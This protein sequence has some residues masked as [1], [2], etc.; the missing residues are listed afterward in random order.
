MTTTNANLCGKCHPNRVSA[1]NDGSGTWAGYGATNPGTHPVGSNVFTDTNGA[2]NSPINATALGIRTFG[3]VAD[4]RLG[5]KIITGALTLATGAGMTCVTCHAVHGVET[6]DGGAAL[7]GT[8][9]E[10]LL[11]VA[12]TGTMDG[13]A[14][15]GR[16]A[17]ARNFLCEACHVAAATWDPA[18]SLAY[19]GTNVPNPGGTQFTHP[20]DDLGARASAGVGDWA[21][22]P[23][24][25]GTATGWPARTSGTI[26]GNVGTTAPIC[27]SCHMPHPLASATAQTSAP[28]ITASATHILRSSETTLCDRCH[29][30]AVGN[31]HPTG[32]AMGRFA[33]SDIVPTGTTLQCG[34]C[35]V[36]S[37]AHNWAAAAGVGL[38]PLWEPSNNARPHTAGQFLATMSKECV[39]CHLYS[40]IT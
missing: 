10:D 23:G 17:N 26:G 12:G 4:Y 32:V 9:N 3:V 24:Q 36:G 40:G 18:T 37:G 2:G 21:I 6:A 27:E 35:H 39:D 38:N 8:P 16:V 14:N 5:P 22:I 28:A 1:S 7:A 13:H 34:H 30:A 31:H 25:T 33:D 19:A 20:A 15:G 29:S 11:A